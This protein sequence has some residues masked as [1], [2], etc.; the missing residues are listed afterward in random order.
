MISP[1]FLKY[2]LHFAGLGQILLCLASLFIPKMLGWKTEL[3]KVSPL[4]RKIFWVYAGYILMTNFSFGLLSFIA[5]SIIMDG[6]VL[7]IC[8]SGFIFLYW[9][10]RLVLQFTV[11]TQYAPKGRVF[12]LG[13]TGLLIS[14]IYFTAVYALALYFNLTFDG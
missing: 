6:S 9:L 11:F 7:A 8:V 2:L 4:I 12:R 3:G 5:P 14:F 1:L 10:T 13:E